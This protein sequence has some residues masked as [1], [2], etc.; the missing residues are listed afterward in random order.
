[1]V[2]RLK[3]WAG[4]DRA[5]KETEVFFKGMLNWELSHHR[6]LD[7]PTIIDELVVMIWRKTQAER[8]CLNE[9]VKRA[10]ISNIKAHPT[11]ARYFDELIAK[12]EKRR[13]I[14]ERH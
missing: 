11:K 12:V 5:V 8:R 7:A 14:T 2:S 1:M 3:W 6:K 13:D 10:A 4:E 9:G